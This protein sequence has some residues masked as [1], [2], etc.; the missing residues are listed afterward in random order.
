[1]AASREL[2]EAAAFWKENR[3]EAEEATEEE[4]TTDGITDVLMVTRAFTFM[5][6]LLFNSS[7]A[8]WNECENKIGSSTLLA[9]FPKA[10]GHVMLRNM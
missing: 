9:S 5:N 7:K 4:Y 10:L 1:M 3:E 8:K 2:A 6:Y